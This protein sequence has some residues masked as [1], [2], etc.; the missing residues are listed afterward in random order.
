[1]VSCRAAWTTQKEYGAIR[2]HAPLLPSTTTCALFSS[3][4]LDLTNM[5]NDKTKQLMSLD[6]LL[7]AS[8][9]ASAE[10]STA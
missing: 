5:T 1:M 4:R 9:R 10:A 2:Y 8:R 6:V 7:L 3:K